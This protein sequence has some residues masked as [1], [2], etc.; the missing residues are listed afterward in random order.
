MTDDS[1]V[2]GGTNPADGVTSRSGSHL[3]FA[4]A[5]AGRTREPVTILEGVFSVYERLHGPRHPSTH[6]A[7][8]NL[9][10]AY[11]HAGRVGD[12]I[13]LQRQVVEAA[14]HI[15]AA[16]PDPDKARENLALMLVEH[17][18]ELQDRDPETAHRHATAA[19]AIAAVLRPTVGGELDELRQSAAL[20][21]SVTRKRPG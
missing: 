15:A 6:T 14:Q 5:G 4:L 21:A 1:A 12:A 2:P 19:L 17:G 7:R 9:A 13:P 11:C 18:W 10:T 20:L 16:Q 3:A 8:A